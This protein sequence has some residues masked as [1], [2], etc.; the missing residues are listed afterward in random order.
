MNYKGNEKYKKS[1]WKCSSC[2]VPDTQEHILV[3]PQYEQ[4][5][6]DKDFNV[7]KHIVDY[8]RS[9][10]TAPAHTKLLYGAY[11]IDK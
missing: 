3:C 1:E 11:L 5:R 2:S 10:R 4:F 9:V 8:F 6:N 7:N